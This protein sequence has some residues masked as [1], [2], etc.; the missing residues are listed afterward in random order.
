M[1]PRKPTW[2]KWGPTMCDSNVSYPRTWHDA[3]IDRGMPVS[4]D[5]TYSGD[6]YAAVGVAILN[7]C[8]GCHATVAPYNSYQISADNPYAYCAMCAGVS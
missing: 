5:G 3:A 1:S 4:E 8:P 2:S 6:D 7:G